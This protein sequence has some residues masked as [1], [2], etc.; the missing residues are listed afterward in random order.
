MA[1]T[2]LV[3]RDQDI[4]KLVCL[5]KLINYPRLRLWKAVLYVCILN[6]G[7]DQ[8]GHCGPSYIRMSPCKYK[9]CG[10]RRSSREPQKAEIRQPQPVLQLCAFCGE[11]FKEFRNFQF[12]SLKPPVPKGRAATSA[13]EYVKP[14]KGK[15]CQPPGAP[16]KRA[17]PSYYFYYF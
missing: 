12:A 1:N 2:I 16:C 14:S 3:S 15:R 7:C 6:S 13:Q 9:W 5:R 8:C 17:Q 10:L 4:Y 11:N